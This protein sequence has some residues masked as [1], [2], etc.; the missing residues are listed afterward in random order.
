MSA[1]AQFQVP[2]PTATGLN[3]PAGQIV[4]GA[5][6]NGKL[7]D[8]ALLLGIKLDLEAEVHLTARVKGDVVVGLY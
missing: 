2:L 8:A 6:D 3:A 4:K 5:E 1:P 7:K